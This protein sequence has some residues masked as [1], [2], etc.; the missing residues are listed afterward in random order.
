MNALP[1][2]HS[3]GLTV[4]SLMPILTGARLF[5]YPSPLHYRNIPEEIYRRQC[6]VLFGSSTFL[7][8]YAKFAHPYDFRQLR[9]AVAGAEKLSAAV[10]DAW[11]D[12]FGIRI[13]EGYGVTETA[14][15]LAV[16]TYMAAR[17]G[18][19]G[20]LVPGVEARLM[21]VP[22]LQRGGVLHVRGPNVMLGYYRYDRP[23]V[24]D[25]V[26]SAF[27]EGWYDTGDVA[28]IDADGY[29]S[30]TGRA[31]RFAK[32][33]GEMVALENTQMLATLVSPDHQHASSA[34]TDAK[35]GEC[36]VLFTTDPALSRE[37]L[38]QIAKVQGIPEIAVARKIVH[39]GQ[40]PMLG[41][42]KVDY[43]RLKELSE[44]V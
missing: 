10:R 29:L 22:G 43:V 9:F 3:F 23:G 31:K 8:N 42:G 17:T 27:G 7:G 41:T 1:V 30:I 14:P 28:E 38:M 20:Q 13:L 40:L 26:R 11:M 24:I 32:I 37:Q 12:K 44:T 15:V 5:L 39:I 21:P 18:T 35:R 16:N 2:F 6:T 4:G 36:I 33:A 34:Q 19:V 25:P